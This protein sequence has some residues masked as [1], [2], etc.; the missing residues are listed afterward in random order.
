MS[1]FAG[2]KQGREE[3]LL[4]SGTQSERARSSRRLESLVEK[5]LQLLVTVDSFLGGFLLFGIT[6]RR[7]ETDLT[8]WEATT[9]VL[10]VIAFGCYFSAIFMAVIL[11]WLDSED[12]EKPTGITQLRRNH[13][14]I[15]AGLS[16]TATVLLFLSI[17]YAAA[18]QLLGEDDQDY[19]A[20]F[21]TAL[22]ITIFVAAFFPGV[23]ALWFRCSGNKANT[24]VDD[25]ADVGE[26]G[27]AEGPA[28][29][30]QVST[31]T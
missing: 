27:Q 9:I 31:S 2:S 4:F 10:Q 17:F 30:E 6:G 1:L 28:D 23:T 8:R 18:A 3:S 21:Y 29:S 7:P 13:L 19:S 11:I 14:T 15:P 22:G 26:R 20:A 5:R 16:F 25:K 24:A 12:E